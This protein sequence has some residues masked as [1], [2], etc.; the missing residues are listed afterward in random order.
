MRL[1]TTRLASFANERST[2]WVHHAE[3]ATVGDLAELAH[4]VAKLEAELNRLRQDLERRARLEAHLTMSQR[5][6]QTTLTYITRL[7][8]IAM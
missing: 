7:V 3:V 8:Q 1:I 5:M 2:R 4:S 6:L